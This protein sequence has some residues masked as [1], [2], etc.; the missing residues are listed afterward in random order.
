MARSSS[1]LDKV[2]R[3]Y[4]ARYGVLSQPLADGVRERIQHG[5][6]AEILRSMPDVVCLLEHNVNK[7]LGR[8]TAGTLRLSEDSQGLRY[9]VDLPPTSYAADAAAAIK[10]GDL[11]AASFGFKL[12][13]GDAD[14]A[15]EI[16]N[17][18]RCMVRTI[19]NF[20]KLFDVSPCSQAWKSIVRRASANTSLLAEP[21]S[22]S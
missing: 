11:N 17:G 21:E 4:A 5:A 6:F 1:S 2:V 15:E 3:G 16:V 10:R 14:Y 20:S 13:P 8:T 19:K 9:E 12:E 7:I 22:R 18:V